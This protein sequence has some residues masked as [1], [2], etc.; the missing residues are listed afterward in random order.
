MHLFNL[1]ALLH[2]LRIQGDWTDREE[3]EPEDEVLDEIPPV[4]E[5]VMAAGSAIP[6]PPIVPPP[7]TLGTP[8]PNLTRGTGDGHDEDVALG[9]E[10]YASIVDNRDIAPKD[11]R[12]RR[13][14]LS[15]ITAAVLHQTAAQR[16]QENALRKSKNVTCHILITPGGNVC[17]NHPWEAYLYAADL[18]NSFSISIEFTGNFEGHPGKGDFYK[19]EKF[20]RGEPTDIQI[21]RGK[22]VLK[23]L[24]YEE[25]LN[26]TTVLAHRQ[27][28]TKRK[29]KNGRWKVAK[30]LDPGWRIYSTVAMWAERVL[31]LD[32]RPQWTL[33]N[34]ATIPDVWEEPPT[35][36]IS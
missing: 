25:N 2:F 11:K 17:L 5:A 9:D 23:W 7:P 8:P 18:F 3:A 21:L 34:G 15:D 36:N 10:F 30:V 20:G 35:T 13:R 1:Q 6:T 26:L 33:G 16:T 32:R 4:T 14:K 19:P 12:K 27:A 22:Q 24:I 29:N 28:R 31:N